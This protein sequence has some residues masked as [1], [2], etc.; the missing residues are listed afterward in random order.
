MLWSTQSID[1]WMDGSIYR[2]GH[3][4]W[5]P[6]SLNSSIKKRKA[7]YFIISTWTIY[8]VV[9]SKK[10]T[11]WID[12]IEWENTVWSP[13]SLNS[14]I[15]KKS[16]MSHCFK[17][18]DIPCCRFYEICN[19]DRSDRMRYAVW[20]PRHPKLIEK[21]RKAE[22]IST[23]I[24]CPEVDSMKCGTWIKTW[25]LQSFPSKKKNVLREKGKLVGL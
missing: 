17:K 25:F 8:P 4:V 2:M 14:S 19:L 7:G 12:L 23:W 20:S 16:L 21:K 13:K 11:I 1:V 15:K 18:E 6:R 22:W 3:A 9:D 24:V 5:T 10:Y